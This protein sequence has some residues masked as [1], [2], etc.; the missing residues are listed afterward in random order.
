MFEPESWFHEVIPLSSGVT[1]LPQTIVVPSIERTLLKRE[2]STNKQC[3]L[4][5]S[6]PTQTVSALSLLPSPAAEKSKE[7]EHPSQLKE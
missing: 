4:F 7:Q 3:A 1:T 5:R 2:Q 6:H